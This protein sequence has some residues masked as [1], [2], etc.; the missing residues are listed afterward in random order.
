MKLNNTLLGVALGAFVLGSAV[1]TSADSLITKISAQMNKGIT[2]V[3][4]G[5]TQNL[6]DGNGQPIYP[7][8][9]NG[10]TYLPLRAT[11]GLFGE[12]VNWDGNTSTIY[13][14]SGEK[15]A[16]RLRDIVTAG[17]YG[18]II[19]DKNLLTVQGPDA[20]MTFDHGVYFDI[21]N[22]FASTDNGRQAEFNATGYETLMFTAYTTVDAKI[23]LFDEAG[24]ALSTQ[25]IK[26][27][28]PTMIE[29]DISGYKAVV[30]L[31]ADA[32][33]DDKFDN[34]MFYAFDAMMK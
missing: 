33:G 4:E 22:G 11:A 13:L 6:K 29:W 3:Y 12:S 17:G 32:T 31:G 30:G 14:G 9:Y 7:I 23:G 16:K 15:T 34:G 2:I 20:P 25:E 8:S 21:W 10:S 24:D 18:G 19:I 5:T 26:A 28:V 27:N 1:T